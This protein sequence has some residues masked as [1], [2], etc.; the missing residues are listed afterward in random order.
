[1]TGKMKT[2]PNTTIQNHYESEEKTKP[3]DVNKEQTENKQKAS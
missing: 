3:R 2:N 1:M